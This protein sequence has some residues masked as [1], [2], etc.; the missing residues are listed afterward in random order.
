MIAVARMITRCARECVVEATPFRAKLAIL[1]F[2][3]EQDGRTFGYTRQMSSGATGGLGGRFD[4]RTGQRVI[5]LFVPESLGLPRV[6][7]DRG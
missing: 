5:S 3:G 2:G 4:A 6:P 7:T 1:Q